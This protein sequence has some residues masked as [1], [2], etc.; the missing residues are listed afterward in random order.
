MQVLKTIW[1]IL[2]NITLAAFLL[3]MMTYATYL[4]DMI[5]LRW[6]RLYRAIFIEKYLL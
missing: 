5:D 4:K 1:T 3:H 6:E 2:K